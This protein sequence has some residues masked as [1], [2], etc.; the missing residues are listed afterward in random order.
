MRNLI[1]ISVL[2]AMLLIPGCASTAQ[3]GASVS[4]S[5][6]F[7]VSYSS[8][9]YEDIDWNNVYVIDNSRI[10]IWIMLPDGRWLLRCRT[11]WWNADY[12]DWYFG[13]WYYDYSIAYSRF[14]AWQ[15]FHAIRF[16]I[17]MHNHYRPWHNRYFHHHNGRYIRRHDIRSH[18]SHNVQRHDVRRNAPIIAREHKPARVAEVRREGRNERP[19]IIVRESKQPV[20]IDGN[21][22]PER[23]E[24]KQPAQVSN[25][26][27]GNRIERCSSRSKHVE[28][29]RS[30][31]GNR[32]SG[33]RTKTTTKTQT[34]RSGRSR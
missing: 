3:A 13:P 20:R 8:C 14:Y 17:Y 10:G 12:D 21:N 23:I 32:E 4:V 25:R 7:G 6:G 19:A 16:H 24:K 5:V 15:P 22:R 11:M 18:S 28:M 31:T 34:R 29:S 26:N 33:N 27:H 30:R 1:G 9:L 2:A